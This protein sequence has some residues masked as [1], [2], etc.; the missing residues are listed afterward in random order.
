MKSTGDKI[1]NGAVWIAIDRWLD[2]SIM[3]AIFVV[4]SR[5]I[6]PQEIGLGAL[7]L[8][9]PL[10]LALPVTSGLNDALVQRPE[11]ERAHLDSGFVLL[12]SIGLALAGLLWF[13]AGM[14]AQ[15]FSQP[16]LSELLRWSCA[17]IVIQALEAVPASLLKR[18]LR[19][20]ILALRS[21]AGTLCGGIAGVVLAMN[22][23]GV[24]S[25]VVMQ[26]VRVA[27]RALIMFATTTWRPA[28]SFSRAHA[29][30]IVNFGAPVSATMFWGYLHEETPKLLIGYIIGP[31]AV[32][33]YVLARRPLD[34]LIN[35]IVAPIQWLALPAVSRIQ[36]NREQVTA[37]YDR[38]VRTSL[39]IAFPAFMGLAVTAADLVPWV[40]GEKWAGVVPVMQILM[41][42]GLM[43][44]FDGICG[45]L[46]I[47]LGHAR[48]IFMLVVA[49]TL[50][51][52]PI[53]MFSAKYGL[54]AATA[55]VVLLQVVNVIILLLSARRITRLHLFRPFRLL[56][57]LIV[58]TA[59]MMLAAGT[60]RTAAAAYSLDT[61]TLLACSVSAG[62]LAYAIA[63]LL[64]LRDEVETIVGLLWRA[65]LSAA[66]PVDQKA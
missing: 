64:L 59:I 23:H 10:L 4:L 48:L 46:L 54:Q 12:A 38:A 34:L 58:A 60:A 21:L 43:R 55:A 13:T 6:G 27:V 66:P 28:P 50:Y 41:F 56:P 57:K 53:L 36:A 20:R 22:G 32:G 65:R 30:D 37:F 26:M 18:D 11:L 39:L 49:S 63:V 1:A 62:A 47:A 52:V 61:P 5:L 7:A 40:L 51:S 17:I 8:A 3:F 16:L 19:F 14:F 33:I 45:G 29:R 15:L 35:V 44:A 9:I 2:Q 25:L 24:W 31:A 42:L